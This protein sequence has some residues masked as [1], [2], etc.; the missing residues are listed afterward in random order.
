MSVLNWA[1]LE[2]AALQ[3]DPFDHLRVAD[4]L[5]PAAAAALPA[6]F[7]AVS[8]LGSFSPKD[9]PPGPLLSQAIEE[10]Q[11]DRF[12]ALMAQ[13]FGIDLDGRATTVTLRGECGERDGYI[14]T[15]SKSKILSLLLY[16][17]EDWTSPEGRLRLL[18][19]GRDL[20]ASAVEIPPTMGSLVVFRR[21][22][23]SWHGHTAFTGRRRSL[24]F[25][26]VRSDRTSLMSDIRHRVSALM[27][28]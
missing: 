8:G 1:S 27:K 4:A 16:L 17:N 2:A 12:R 10:L 5:Q 21:S 19:N 23:R 24:Q 3:T 14:H 28:G 7:P 20:E 13:R 9:A 15:D 25:N 22:E 11:S 6:E 26:Y 18:R